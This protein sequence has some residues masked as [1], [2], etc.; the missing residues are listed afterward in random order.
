MISLASDFQNQSCQTKK[1][2]ANLLHH[3][4]LHHAQSGFRRNHSCETALC[5]LVDMWTSNM[6]SGLINGAVFIDLRKAFDMVQICCYENLQF[7]DVMV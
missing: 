4:L 7:T 1:S 2:K 5:K 6:E 3:N